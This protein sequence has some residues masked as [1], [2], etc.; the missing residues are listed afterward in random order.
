MLIRSKIMRATLALAAVVMA[1]QA[2]AQVRSVTREYLNAYCLSNP[3]YYWQGD[4]YY[5]RLA[6]DNRYRTIDFS[7]V[8]VS[9]IRTT[10]DSLTFNCN[11]NC[12]WTMDTLGGTGRIYTTV[13]ILPIYAGMSDLQR[14]RCIR[15]IANMARESG[16]RN[17]PPV[18]TFDGAPRPRQDLF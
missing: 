2:T 7:R 1:G 14:G 8:Q 5:Q 6:P 9:S 4:L 13:A 15:A 17:A 12:R 11:G 18:T 10:A 16:A 3:I